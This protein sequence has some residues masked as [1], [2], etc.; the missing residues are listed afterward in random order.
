[1][2]FLLSDGYLT[3]GVALWAGISVLALVDP[4]FRVKI[5]AVQDVVSLIPGAGKALGKA[6]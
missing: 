5:G 4:S 3:A 6:K 2:N 1:L